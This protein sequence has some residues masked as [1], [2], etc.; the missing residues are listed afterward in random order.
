MY[1]LLPSRLSFVSALSFGCAIPLAAPAFGE[2]DPAI[3]RTELEGVKI[4]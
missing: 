4:R 2:K 1:V 3:F